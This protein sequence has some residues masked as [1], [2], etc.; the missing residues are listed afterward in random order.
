MS[1]SSDLN[2]AVDPVPGSR[3]RRP[4]ARFGLALVFV[5]FAGYLGSAPSAASLESP[6]V[7]WTAWAVSG[8]VLRCRSGLG[9]IADYR[10]AGAV[11][12]ARFPAR[13]A[14]IWGA[15][16]HDAPED[17]GWQTSGVWSE[18]GAYL[19]GV[20]G[21]GP[22]RGLVAGWFRRCASDPVGPVEQ[23]TVYDVLRGLD[24][25]PPSPA[26]APVRGVVGLESVL[27]PPVPQPAMYAAGRLDVNEGVLVEVRV[28]T[29]TVY[30]GEVGSGQSVAGAVSPASSRFPSQP[31]SHVYRRSGRYPV[32][33]E[34]EWSARWRPTWDQEWEPISIGPFSSTMRFDVDEI[35]SR[36]VRP[37]I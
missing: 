6:G 25:S 24:Y 11:P 21:V 31:F 23:L 26:P 34:F 35:V 2:P 4:G 8:P 27:S 18:R 1:E 32:T 22:A 7:C 33:V 20:S 9:E 37:G 10:D 17:T 14:D 29:V 15:C 5:F 36:L 28:R 13:G 30:W 19:V 12:H 16:W 3:S